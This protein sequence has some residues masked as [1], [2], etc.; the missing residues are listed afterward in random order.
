MIL[1]LV[2]SVI[3]LLCLVLLRTR[4]V[5]VVWWKKNRRLK[6]TPCRTAVLIRLPVGKCETACVDDNHGG[7]GLVCMH[8]GGDEAVLGCDGF[9]L[10][11]LSYWDDAVLMHTCVYE[12]ARERE[13][14]RA[15]VNM[16]VI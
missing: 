4:P 14:A 6:R 8:G 11:G 16:N 7:H 1:V 13:I 9:D 3:L 15:R 2:Y 10:V 5:L 12:T